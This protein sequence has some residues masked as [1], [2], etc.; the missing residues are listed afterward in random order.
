MTRRTIGLAAVALFAVPAAAQD[1][2]ADVIKAAMKASGG[3]EL[4][5]KYPAGMSKME[6]KMNV[7]MT[8]L[9]FT[10]TM[11][12]AAPGKVKMDL[13]V[14]VGG[15]KVTL[16]QVVNEKTARQTEN[17]K[18]VEMRANAKTEL[19]QGALLQEVALLYPL[20]DDK[21]YRLWAGFG[22][23]DH[24]EV[25]VEGKD[26][27]LKRVRL[28]FNK[29]TKLLDRMARRGLNPAGTE[30]DEVTEY[31]DYKGVAGLMVPMVSKVSHDG[32]PFLDIKVTEFK[33]LEKTDEK[34][35]TGN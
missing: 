5:R 33:P 25:G 17:G 31:A 34:F 16:S 35:D 19:L 23:A 13:V 8:S 30:V 14:E 24:N 11:V 26:N 21:Q 6:G 7:G 12:F 29:K 18:I 9:P 1:T 32:K 4:L 27:G 3:E 15:M 2:A 28:F 10:G 22:T 20:L